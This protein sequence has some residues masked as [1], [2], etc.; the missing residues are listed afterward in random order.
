MLAMQAKRL[1]LD[2]KDPGKN[3]VTAECICNP[4]A[5]EVETGRFMGCA[6]QLV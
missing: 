2:L 6:G 5:T 3:L 4:A 1:N